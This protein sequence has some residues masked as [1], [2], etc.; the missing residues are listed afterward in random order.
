MPSTQMCVLD[1]KRYSVSME[2]ALHLVFITVVQLY[3]PCTCNM[4]NDVGCVRHI[5][6]PNMWF[7]KSLK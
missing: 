5:Y 1:S 3:N 6:I 7:C 2:G 4:L